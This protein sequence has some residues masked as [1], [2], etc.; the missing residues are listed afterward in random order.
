MKRDQS[1]GEELDG[2][3]QMVK[4][5]PRGVGAGDEWVQQT[6]FGSTM[7]PQLLPAPLRR[8]VSRLYQPR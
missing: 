1:V 2:S 8:A 4:G 7:A 3:A 5:D 6:P